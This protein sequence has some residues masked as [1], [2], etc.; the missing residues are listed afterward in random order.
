MINKLLLSQT[1]GTN[2]IIAHLL[3]NLKFSVCVP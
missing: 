3:D 2:K 1:Q